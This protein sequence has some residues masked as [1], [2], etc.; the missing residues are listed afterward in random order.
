MSPSKENLE[1]L[2]FSHEQ[3][4]RAAFHDFRTGRVLIK[5]DIHIFGHLSRHGY[6]IMFPEVDITSRWYSDRNGTYK[7]GFLYSDELKILSRCHHVNILP[8]IGYCDEKDVFLQQGAHGDKVILIYNGVNDLDQTLVGYL[9]NKDRRHHSWARRLRICIGVA[10]GLNYL[11]SGIGS[12]DTPSVALS[13][14]DYI[15]DFTMNLASVSKICDSE[16]DVKFSISNCTIYDR[17][18]PEVVGIGHR[19]GDLCVLGHFRVN[20]D[21]ASSTVDVSSFWLNR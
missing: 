9:Q 18:T 17:K 4:D 11:H 20:H 12:L 13:N 14:F 3:I 2:G 10:K 5:P 21:T 15:P 19:Q 8:F 1:K 16:F 6:V 7:S